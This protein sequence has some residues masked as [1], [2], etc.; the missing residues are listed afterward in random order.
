[1]EELITICENNEKEIYTPINGF[2][3]EN[4]Y[5]GHPD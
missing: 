5:K 3:Y 1:M 4:T 2:Y